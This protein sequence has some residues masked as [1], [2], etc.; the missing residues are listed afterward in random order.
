MGDLQQ[1]I[2]TLEQLT[3]DA[4]TILTEIIHS[5]T[6]LNHT[7][8][9]SFQEIKRTYI[10]EARKLTDE[11]MNQRIQKI[12]RRES[13]TGPTLVKAGTGLIGIGFAYLA[14]RTGSELARILAGKAFEGYRMDE[15]EIKNIQI[16]AETTKGMMEKKILNI[17]REQFMRFLKDSKSMHA[18]LNTLFKQHLAN[19]TNPITDDSQT[20]TYST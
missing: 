20:P 13:K 3:V 19:N 2:S 5:E 1:Y 9:S 14:Q 4:R 6:L 12:E 17:Q 18:S 15:V 16:A 11:I 7:L 8:D 10:N